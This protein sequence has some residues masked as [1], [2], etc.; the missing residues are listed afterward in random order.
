VGALRP[1]PR[2]ARDLPIE[3][4]Q[5]QELSMSYREYCD[6]CSESYDDENLTICQECQRWFCY[7]CGSCGDH[8]CLRCLGKRGAQPG[9]RPAGGVEAERDPAAQDGEESTEQD[10]RSGWVLVVVEG[11]DLGRVCLLGQKPVAIGRGKDDGFVLR[12]I[13]VTQRQLEIEWDPATS[14]H[15]LRQAGDSPTVINNIPVSRLAGVQHALMKGDQ[16]QVGSTILR[17]CR[18]GPGSQEPNLPG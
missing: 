15:F 10:P 16:I 3:V 11:P 2:Q 9:D 13:S 1:P 6:L 5:V 4:R 14:Q 8:L 18:R 12:D 17:Y 7:R